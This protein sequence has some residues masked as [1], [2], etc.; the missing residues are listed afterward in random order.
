M[1]CSG[2]KE[3]LC[4]GQGRIQVYKDFS[5]KSPTLEELANGI[6]DI[7]ASIDATR[8]AISTYH[9]HLEEL[10]DLMDSDLG[11]NTR[12][13][14]DE[15]QYQYIRMEVLNSQREL[16]AASGKLDSTNSNSKL[17][18][19]K[20]RQV[21]ING[22]G[23]LDSKWQTDITGT[24]AAA[25]LTSGLIAHYL[26]QPDLKAQFQAGGPLQMVMTVKNY[27][28][29]QG[30][31]YKGLNKDDGIPRAALGDLVPCSSE[32]AIQ[33]TPDGFTLNFESKDRTLR[34][35]VVTQGMSYV[36]EDMPE[37]RVFGEGD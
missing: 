19:K 16:H 7:T 34:T 5:W 25:A 2:D 15:D 18:L 29:Q 1:P 14:R 28:R 30:V 3:K 31:L 26:S 36:M 22:K 17:L 23:N 6:H 21:D 10:Q 33:G 20:G 32:E 24:S 12:V 27:V 37:C 13:K 4:G 8:K 9:D 11:S 35:K